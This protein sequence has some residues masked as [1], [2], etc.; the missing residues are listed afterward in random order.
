V[1]ETIRGDLRLAVDRS[2]R[3]VPVDPAFSMTSAPAL[4]HAALL[5]CDAE[6]ME[7]ALEWATRGSFQLL[8]FLGPFT[9]CCRALLDGAAADH[10]GEF[11]DEAVAVPVWQLFALPLVNAALIGA[12][13][14]DAARAVADRAAVLLSDMAMYPVLNTALHLAQAQVGLAR[15]CLDF[16]DHEARAAL[17]SALSQGF[18]LAV[19]DAL[20]LRAAVAERSGDMVRVQVACGGARLERDRL[21]CR[22]VSTH[23]DRWPGS[24]LAS[25]TAS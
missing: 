17:D 6:T 14:A 23:A 1:A 8:R 18:P 4:A 19:V 10:A 5:S 22:F 15:G 3:P 11:W 7:R 2:R 13:R 12:G 16:A 21:G 20:E 25:V 24:P 9:S